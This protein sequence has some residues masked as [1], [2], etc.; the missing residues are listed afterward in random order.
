[1]SWV[2]LLILSTNAHA[3]NF[4]DFVLENGA[5]SASI[6]DQN[7]NKN[8]EEIIFGEPHNGPQQFWEHT[9]INALFRNLNEAKKAVKK[10]EKK[11]SIKLS[12]EFKE[13]QDEDWVKKTQDQFHP[14]S[15]NNKLWIIPTWHDVVDK[16]AINLI[17]DPGLA[18]GTGSHPTTYLC[19]EWL[20]NNIQK[21]SA[22]LDYG[23]G[24]GILSI[25]AKKLGADE[26]LGVDIDPQAIS[27]SIYNS[28]KNKVLIEFSNTKKTTKFKADII[29]A[30]I[31]SSA[32][33]VLA[34]VLASYCKKNGKIALSGVLRNQE[35]EITD[36]Y[37]KWFSMKKSSYKG[38]W[39]CLSGIKI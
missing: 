36:I 17:L 37:S 34:P 21:K 2:N 23:C 10:L 3:D 18:F 38:E 4:S 29:V 30:N 39:V 28:Q 22:V 6:Q 33:K 31:L 13:V 32:L 9:Q 5:I 8:N 16:N 14:I 1:M 26:V 12:V 27:A 19:I 25:C 35:K 15:I 7:L 11:F 24:S 20:I